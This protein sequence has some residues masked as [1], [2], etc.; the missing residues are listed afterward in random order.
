MKNKS[1]RE[2]HDSVGD[3]SDGAEES[4]P[5]MKIAEAHFVLYVELVAL[6]N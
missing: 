1:E 6:L 2:D 5:E 4:S 3:Q